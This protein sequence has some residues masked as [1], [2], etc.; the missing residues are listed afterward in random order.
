MSK[1]NCPHCEEPLIKV[2]I[3]ISAAFQLWSVGERLLTCTD[4][5]VFESDEPRCWECD[6]FV[7]E[8]LK[9]NGIIC[10][11]TPEETEEG[12]DDG[13]ALRLAGPGP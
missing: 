10:S 13:R 7:G 9:A 11:W 6:G 12:G 2:V 4:L 1:L 8:F 5:D 3:H